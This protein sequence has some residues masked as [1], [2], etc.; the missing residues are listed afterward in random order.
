MKNYEELTIKDDFM[1]SKVMSRPDLCKEMIELLLDIEVEKVE[2]VEREYGFAPLIDKHSIRLDV[3]VKNSDKIFDIEI[4]TT[5]EH[6]LE[7]RARY[8]QSLMDIDEFEKSMDYNE[9]KETFIVFICTFDPFGDGFLKYDVQQAILDEDGTILANYDDSTHKIFYNLKSKELNES[10]SKVN[11]FLRYLATNKVEGDLAS[12]VDLAFK[13]AKSYNA[14]RLEYMI[15]Q[16]KLDSEYKKGLKEGEIATKNA[17]VLN[18]LNSS[19]SIDEISKYTGL[20]KEY[21]LEV[22]EKL[23][24]FFLIIKE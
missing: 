3:Y 9:L 4:Q 13:D 20:T 11:K 16:E 2:K 23:K 22:K 12:K 8:Y 6:N 15:L 24:L 17:V 19:L 1:F 7:L 10:N 18:M 14:W 21:I 5:N